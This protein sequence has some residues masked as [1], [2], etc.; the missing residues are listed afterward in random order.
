MVFSK[1]LYADVV[2]ACANCF[3]DSALVAVQ[4]VCHAVD[5]LDGWLAYNRLLKTV[6][7]K[8]PRLN[9]SGWVVVGN[10]RVWSVVAWWTPF[11]LSPFM[12]L[13][14]IWVLY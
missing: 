5:S 11:P 4:Q 10:W 12:D 2:Q 3:P 13:S 8:L 9:L 14:E 6:S 1:Q 7:L